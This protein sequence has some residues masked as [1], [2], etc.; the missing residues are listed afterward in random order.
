MIAHARQELLLEILGQKKHLTMR[1]LP[2]LLKASPA[3]IRRDISLLER[4]G[5]LVHSHG[6]ISHPEHVGGEQ[7]FARKTRVATSAKQA[8]A[9][10][11]VGLVSPGSVVFID[12][13]TTCLEIGRRLLREEVTIY[14]NSIPLLAEPTPSKAR[15]VSLG[16]EVRHVSRA[17]VGGLALEWLKHLRFDFAFL[18]ASGLCPTEGASTTELTEAAIKR[19]CAGRSRRAILVADATKWNHPVSVQFAPWEAF[20]DLV[21]DLRLAQS[22]RDRLQDF[23]VNIHTVSIS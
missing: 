3:T 15:V 7:S 2:S 13:G 9:A 1:K 17:L 22:D 6:S 18:G 14:T 10:Y 20:D 23:G 5:K 19:E 8:I 4:M 11:T 12:S 21:T 16:G